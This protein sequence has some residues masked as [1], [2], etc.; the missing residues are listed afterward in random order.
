MCVSRSVSRLCEISLIARER[1]VRR[2]FSLSRSRWACETKLWSRDCD[3]QRRF[4]L[5]LS[6]FFFPLPLY[7]FVSFSADRER[8]REQKKKIKSDRQRN[9]QRGNESKASVYEEE[10]GWIKREK[11]IRTV[12]TFIESPCFEGGRPDGKLHWHRIR[13]A[14]RVSSILVLRVLEITNL[15]EDSYSFSISLSLRFASFIGVSGFGSYKFSRGIYF[16]R[17]LSLARF[18]DSLRIWKWVNISSRE[19]YSTVAAIRCAAAAAG[20]AV[21][22]LFD[23]CIHV[24]AQVW[25]FST[26]AESR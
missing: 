20:A 19:V 22:R 13:R 5:S 14:Q 9:R 12:A 8:E 18:N 17:A 7:V 23:F 2:V 1:L 26:R 11:S 3:T 6:I 15:R 10:R 16:N 4:Q 21:Y 24:K 25:P